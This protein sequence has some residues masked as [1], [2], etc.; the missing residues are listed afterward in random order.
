M[1]WESHIII[2]WIVGSVINMLLIIA[3]TYI[4]SFY[5]SALAASSDHPETMKATQSLDNPEV[6][7]FYDFYK[8]ILFKL[9]YRAFSLMWPASM[10]IYWNKRKHLHKK[11]VQ[12][13]QDWFGTPT[14]GRRFLVLGH[15]YGHHDI[16]WK[17]SILLICQLTCWL[18]WSICWLMSTNIDQ[19]LVKIMTDSEVTYQLRGAFSTQDTRNLWWNALFVC[20]QL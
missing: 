5:S 8:R 7:S 19:D 17:H 11:K 6:Q 2:I 1:T 3:R 16:M 14:I 18:T 12:L 10:Q 9:Y 15:Q 20:S 4:F 13:P